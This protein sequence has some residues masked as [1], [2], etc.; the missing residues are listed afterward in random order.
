M[1]SPP[2]T[3]VV[4]FPFD[5]FG[6]AGTG[7]GARLLGDALREAVDDTEAESQL[8][9]PHNFAHRLDFREHPFETMDEVKDWHTDGRTTIR[10]HLAHGD[11]V[12]WL[13]GN[14]LSILPVY[15]ELT[16]RDLVVQFDAHLDVYDLHDVT[17]TLSPGNFLRHADRKVPVVNVGHRDLFLTPDDIRATFVAS[18][19]AEELAVDLGRVVTD[20]RKRVRRAARVWIDL[21]VDVFDP[22]IAP[23]V[24]HP[25]PF[26]IVSPQFLAVLDA[27][28]TDKVVGMSVS[29][30]DPGRDDRDRTLNLLGWLLERIL[31]RKY[32]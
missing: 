20:L 4:V 28:W 3:T 9:R 24:Q 22:S 31:L 21:D 25:L 29:E 11:F 1:N 2:R 26:G 16:A 30:F 15:E 10:E 27:V 7:D 14:H 8:T 13:G 23:A 18:H 6:N 5:L 32:E 19:P 12:L 17:E